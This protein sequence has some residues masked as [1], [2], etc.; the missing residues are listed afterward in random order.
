[1]GGEAA[2]FCEVPHL[3]ALQEALAFARAQSLPIY[4]LGKGSN[5]LFHDR[6]FAGCVIRLTMDQVWDEGEGRFRAEAGVPFPRLGIHTARKGFGGL[7]FAS[8]IP[9]SVGGAVAMNAGA[10]GRETQD[11][12]VE[13]KTLSYSGVLHTYPAS[14]LDFTYR[15][16]P[17]LTSDEVI[18]EATFQLQKDPLARERQVELLAKRKAS[19]PVSAFSAGCVFRN[20]PGD[21]AGRLIEAS[22]LKGVRLGGAQVSSL[23]ANFLVNTGEATCEEM[24]ALIDHVEKRVHEKT[25]VTLQR[26]V[27]LIPC[28]FGE[29]EDV[30]C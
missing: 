19:Q 18:V 3:L 30:S 13:V 6:G 17:F 11:S 14:S 10:N 29:V 8:G 20:P 24:L 9:G 7:E 27:R 2:Y 15:S 5:S 1:M 22:G 26:E 23:H 25:G 12:L 16:S 21:S 4:I 28:G